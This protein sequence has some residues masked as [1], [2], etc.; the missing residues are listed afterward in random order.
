MTV[1]V[2][3][4]ALNEAAAIG[5]VI[6]AIPRALNARVIVVDNGSTD[7]TAEVAGEHGAT[8][9]VEPRRGY[10]AACLRGLATLEAMKK[11]EETEAADS[12][13]ETAEDE[14]VV[15]LDGDFSDHPEEMPA[16]V[17]PIRRGE[18]DLVIGSRVRGERSPGALTPQ[19]VFGNWLATR[20]LWILYGVRATD[21]GPFR[22]IRRDALASLGMRDPDFGWTVE[23]Q[24][25]AAR[26]G[27][28]VMEVPVRYRRRIGKSKISGT[29][30]GCIRAASKIFVLTVSLYFERPD[31]DRVPVR[32]GGTDE[33]Q[34]P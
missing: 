7:R 4:P 27:L 30:A 17:E 23:M 16:L 31:R 34:H 13:S 29:L 11:T 2:L 25:R 19:Q 5:K 24:I 26:S 10:G 3:I 15:F 28:R 20:L 1:T 18:A 21:L 22:A 8:V 33:T 32:P 9:A 6:D 12:R 14:I